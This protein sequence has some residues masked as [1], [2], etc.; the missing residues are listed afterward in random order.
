MKHALIADEAFL[1]FLESNWSAILVRA[2]DIIEPLIR[3]AA[4]IK[5]EVVMQDEKEAGLRAILNFGHT[6]GHAIE[7]VAGYGHYT[8][9]EAVALGMRAA[10][11]LSQMLHPTLDA[12]RAERL[13]RQ[14]PIGAEPIALPVDALVSATKTDKKALGDTVRFVLLK[15]V[16]S[17]Y[18]ENEAPPEGVR[19]A[20]LHVISAT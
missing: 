11:L 13:V 20:F 12:D 18:V 3:R 4:E 8:H 2:P 17:A 7:Q 1:S 14:I 9:G 6:F 15:R 16:G 5:V 10:L 19:E